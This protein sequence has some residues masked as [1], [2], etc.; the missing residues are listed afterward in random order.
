MSKLLRA[1]T[2]IG[3]PVVTLAGDSPF[4]VKDV[5]FDRQAGDIVGFTLRKHGFLGSPVKEELAWSDVHGMGPDAVVVADAEALRRPEGDSLTASG[6]N[7]LGDRVLT[8]NGTDL[9]EVVEAIIS[10]GAS[11]DVVGFEIEPSEHLQTGGSQN[12]FLPLPDALGISGENVIVP[13]TAKE[14]I[15]DDLSG[16]GGAVDNFRS[17][18]KAGK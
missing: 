15:S 2:L 7:V 18:L 5:V 10:T 4:E 3:R 6:G 13:D 12:V 11:A 1:S 17:Q 9:G 16:F 14:Y 8:E